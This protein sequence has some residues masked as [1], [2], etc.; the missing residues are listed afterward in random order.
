MPEDRFLTDLLN[1]YNNE[2]LI[3]LVPRPDFNLMTLGHSGLLIFWRPGAYKNQQFSLVYVFI[4]G[5]NQD[6]RKISYI[7]DKEKGQCMISSLLENTEY[8]VTIM[9]SSKSREKVLNNT[10]VWMILNSL[11][12]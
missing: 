9:L 4:E 5:R 1:H 3:V 8:E 7:L 6:S 12:I 10:Y 11:I 2:L